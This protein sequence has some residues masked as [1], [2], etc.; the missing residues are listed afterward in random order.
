MGNTTWLHGKDVD[1]GRSEK[2]GPVIYCTSAFFLT[3][4]ILKHLKMAY[5]VISSWLKCVGLI[6]NEVGHIFISSLVIV[7]VLV[8]LFGHAHGMQKIL[9]RNHTH[10]TAITRATAVIMLDT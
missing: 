1:V 8:C 7:F 5:K 3:F 6:I 4:G 10:V 2:L 9:Y